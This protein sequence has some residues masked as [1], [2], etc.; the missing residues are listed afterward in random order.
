MPDQVSKRGFLNKKSNCWVSSLL[1]VLHYSPLLGCLAVSRKPFA[2]KLYS[3]FQN[4]AKDTLVSMSIV[5]LVKVTNACSMEMNLSLHQ[6]TDELYKNI[7]LNLIADQSFVDQMK[8]LFELKI[9][10]VNRCIKCNYMNCNEELG[11]SINL[12]M[13][14]IGKTNIADLNSVLRLF[15]TS[16]L[17]KSAK[18]CVICSSSSDLHQFKILQEKPEILF[19][20]LERN[21]YDFQTKSSKYI[22]SRI[23][24]ERDRSIFRS[25]SE[26]G[27][28]NTMYKLAST[29]TQ[30]GGRNINIGYF[31]CYVFTEDEIIMYEDKTATRKIDE[32]LSSNVKFHREVC[33]VTY[34]LD[35]S[36]STFLDNQDNGCK[37]FDWSV[38]TKE[39]EYISKLFTEESDVDLG[40]VRLESIKTLYYKK[41]VHSEAIDA[42]F[43]FI[44]K[45][46]YGVTS[47]SFIVMNGNTGESQIEM[48]I[49]KNVSKYTNIRI[50]PV[51]Y[52]SNWFSIVCYL[53]EKIIF[54]F[55]SL[56]TKIKVNVFKRVLFIIFSLNKIEISDWL[57]LQPLN[58]PKQVDASSCGIHAI[59]NILFLLQLGG[60]YHQF[61][62]V[63]S[64]I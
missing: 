9:I 4:M 57:S 39:N 59:L 64:T 63:N 5:E 25:I 6:D 1:Q 54:C 16:Q 60:T 17:H 47:L 22:D 27:G 45:E 11:N 61:D 24:I 10:N 62:I 55:D 33:A 52:C 12:P 29:V 35:N 13:P 49:R 34:C 15:F 41:W 2:A 30:S 8:T 51:I 40:V 19:M 26:T 32:N 42:I 20:V 14:L 56:Y 23:K 53:K 7:I 21:R 18:V 28:E 48:E 43:R 46:R 58:I 38:T 36:T 44:S 31:T 50:I 3:L 37:N